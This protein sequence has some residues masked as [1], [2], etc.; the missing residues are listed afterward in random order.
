L[1]RAPKDGSGQP[2][3][4][5]D[6]P[7]TNLGQEITTDADFIYWLAAD[8]LLR[9]AKSGGE[10]ETIKLAWNHRGGA[11]AADNGYAYAAMWG[12]RAITRIDH[13][14]RKVRVDKRRPL[15]AAIQCSQSS[16]YELVLWCRA[17]GKAQH[18]VCVQKDAA[19]G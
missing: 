2:E 12:C 9:R 15:S 4:I 1:F 5:G 14:V 7:G 16:A 6:F 17:I 19:H 10:I 11:I 8:T 18:D 13:V 3:R